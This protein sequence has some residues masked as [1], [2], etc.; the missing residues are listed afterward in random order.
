MK[1][2]DGLPDWVESVVAG[3]H[4]NFGNCEKEIDDE[5]DDD[6]SRYLRNC[7]CY[8]FECECVFAIL[9]EEVAEEYDD[10]VVVGPDEAAEKANELL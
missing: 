7:R 3:P 2:T 1:R 9:P 10:E 5:E 4:W 8:Y 6:S